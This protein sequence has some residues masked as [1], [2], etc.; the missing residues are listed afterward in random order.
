MP[1]MP[2]C[3]PLAGSGVPIAGAWGGRDCSDLKDSI[4]STARAG[5]VAGT[6]CLPLCRCC[7]GPDDLLSLLQ[8]ALR[9]QVQNAH[10]CAQAEVAIGKQLFHGFVA[11]L[12]SKLDHTA[13]ARASTVPHCR[14]P[15]A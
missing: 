1:R 4:S 10:G 3:G 15:V 12:D 5:A 2:G 11:E 13:D 7:A 14:C 6:Q 9:T 8:D